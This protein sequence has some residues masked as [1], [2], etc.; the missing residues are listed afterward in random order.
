MPTPSDTDGPP[1]ALPMGSKRRLC[2]ISP[3]D[4]NGTR[5][6]ATR[7]YLFGFGAGPCFCVSGGLSGLQTISDRGRRRCL[8]IGFRSGL[9]RS[10]PTVASGQ[11]MA[12]RSKGGSQQQPSEEPRGNPP[13]PPQPFRQYEKRRHKTG[14]VNGDGPVICVCRRWST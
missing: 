5:H 10:A 9:K 7:R 3:R 8:R 4:N 14:R 12:Q 6:I 11:R 1:N 13:Q 2:P